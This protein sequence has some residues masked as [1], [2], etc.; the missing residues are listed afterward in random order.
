[1]SGPKIKFVLT[2]T[3]DDDEKNVGGDVNHDKT[4]IY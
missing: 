4:G 2:S 1:M 3:A